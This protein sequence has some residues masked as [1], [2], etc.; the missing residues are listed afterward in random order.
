MNAA[1]MLKS[2]TRAAILDIS[3]GSTLE[4]GGYCV[5]SDVGAAAAAFA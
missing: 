4:I 1:E 2:L 3:Y 5:T